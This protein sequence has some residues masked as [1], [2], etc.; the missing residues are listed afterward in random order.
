[1]RNQLLKNTIIVHPSTCSICPPYTDVYY[2]TAATVTL[3]SAYVA[4]SRNMNYLLAERRPSRRDRKV[5]KDIGH[6]VVVW[7][8]LPDLV[9][10]V[11]PIVYLSEANYEEGVNW[12][13]T[14]NSICEWVDCVWM[15]RAMARVKI[16]SDQSLKK[17]KISK[18]LMLAYLCK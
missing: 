14:L 13:F 15:H 1:M 9:T 5:G 6:M 7:Y 2:V 11:T 10:T 4:A 16:S 17:L 18:I 8:P 12:R 3:R